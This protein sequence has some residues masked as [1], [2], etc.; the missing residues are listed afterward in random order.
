MNWGLNTRTQ[1]NKS[2]S[3]GR[4]L[5]HAHFEPTYWHTNDLKGRM[6]YTCDDYGCSTRHNFQVPLI[7][8]CTRSIQ[9]YKLP[10]VDQAHG[11]M[12]QSDS[13]IA[14][15]DSRQE[16]KGFRDWT[17]HAWRCHAL[18]CHAFNSRCVKSNRMHWEWRW[19]SRSPN[20]EW[21]KDNESPKEMDGNDKAKS[22]ENWR[23]WKAKLYFESWPVKQ[24]KSNRTKCRWNLVTSTWLCA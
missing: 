10:D 4:A 8:N 5:F 18:L 24:P 23:W 19:C 17:L 3:R 16:M 6:Y 2:S 12:K 9:N 1:T 13:L 15:T 21:T 14:Q 11:R 20:M 22:N 7:L